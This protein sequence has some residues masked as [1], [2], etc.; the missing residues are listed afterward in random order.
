MLN[1]IF[2]TKLLD[3]EVVKSTAG[4]SE[5]NYYKVA[6]EPLE[7]GYGHTMGNG[8]RRVLLSSIAGAA[9]TKVKIAG[10]DHQFT[11]LEGMREDIVEFILNLKQIRLSL[12][13]GK[14]TILKLSAKG[15][16][17]VTA[18]DIKTPSTVTIV[19][20][21]LVIANLASTK[22]KLEAEITVKPGVGYVMAE[23]D[24]S[25]S[26]GE[27]PVDALFSPI[28]KVA[29][30]IEATRVGRRTD[31]DKLVMEIWTDGTINA[32]DALDHASRVLVSHFKQVYEPVVAEEEKVVAAP[33]MEND[34]LNLTVEELG[35]P[36]RIANALR[37]GGYKTV[38]D[39][40][41]G[42][43]SAIAKV[44]NL[45]EKSV[46]TVADALAKYGVKLKD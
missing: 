15:P 40:V 29:Y 34:N 28:T 41:E 1:T 12:T 22:T 14:E 36:T 24:D 4:V 23:S 26:F 5:G 42:E 21:D 46:V 11:T 43:S 17:I 3:E 30:R 31:F 10:I 6:I 33:S 2:T 27:I 8:L 7:Q 25:L 16:G 38:K 35:I 18:G 20:P 19:N 9:I 39:L 13:D 45:G 44:K 32:M 37:K